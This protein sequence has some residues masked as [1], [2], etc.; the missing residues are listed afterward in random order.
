V[1]RLDEEGLRELLLVALTLSA[2]ATDAISSGR[3]LHRVPGPRSS[4]SS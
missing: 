4:P 1:R 2:G 3:V